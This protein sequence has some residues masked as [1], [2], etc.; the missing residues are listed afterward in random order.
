MSATMP[1]E[2]ATIFDILSDPD[3]LSVYLRLM[4]CCRSAPIRMTPDQALSWISDVAAGTGLVVKTVADHLAIL[5]KTGLVH[6]SV[7]AE[8]VDCRF[9]NHRF[10]AMADIF[11]AADRGATTLTQPIKHTKEEP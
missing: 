7:D 10:K 5:K 4:S 2:T 8:T 1:D 6:V 11:H 9:D 3:R